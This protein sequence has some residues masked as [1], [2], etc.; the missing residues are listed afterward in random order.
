MEE[1]LKFFGS[2]PAVAIAWICTVVSCIYAFV[3]KNNATKI[4]Q[5][6]NSLNIT[7]ENLK[8]QN[9]CLEQKITNIEKNNIYENYREVNQSGKTNISQGVIKG[10]FHFTQ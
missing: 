10:D 8:I 3:Q 4:E 5:K 6:F 7:Y 1:V 9:S 2:S